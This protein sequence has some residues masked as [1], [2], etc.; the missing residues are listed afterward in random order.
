MSPEEV[1]PKSLGELRQKKSEEEFLPLR[2][3]FLRTWRSQPP[4]SFPADLA[5]PNLRT[6]FLRT[7]VAF[8]TLT[9]P[10]NS[11]LTPLRTL[12]YTSSALRE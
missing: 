3:H 1:S 10:S 5:K 7:S 8:A 11:Y 12:L 9:L 4:D 6:L 2:T